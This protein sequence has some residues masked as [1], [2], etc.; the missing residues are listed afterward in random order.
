MTTRKQILQ[1][2]QEQ[3]KTV[4]E[5][6]SE[7]PCP[8]KT[9]TEMEMKIFSLQEKKDTE[10]M[11]KN[12][13]VKQRCKC[14]LIGSSQPIVAMLGDDVILPCHMEP[15]E[16]ASYL[17]LEWTRPDLDRRFVCVW[18]SGEELVAKKHEHFKGRTSLFQDEL[19]LG[20][21]SL[22][23]SK[24]KLADQGT[25]RCF[26]PVLGK[27]T[28]VQLVVD[29]LSS[30]VLT[31]AGI[32]RSSRG[33]ILS[34]ESEGWYPQPE[35]SWL[36]AEGNLLP[37]GPTETVRGPDGLYAVSSRVS[38]EKRH[39]NTFTCR[40][41]QKNINRMTETEIYILDDFFEVQSCSSAVTVGLADAKKCG[42]PMN[43][44][45]DDISSA[46]QSSTA[47]PVIEVDRG[48]KF[49][50]LRNMSSEEQQLGSWKLKIQ[51][52]RESFT[53]TFEESFKLSHQKSV[54]LWTGGH[55]HSRHPTHLVWKE[56]KSWSPGD[57]LHVVLSS[58][59]GETKSTQ[60]KLL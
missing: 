31:L 51:I 19:K 42:T 27:Q 43:S 44:Q 6:T 17:M 37:A 54:T 46:S 30:P 45:T 49:I 59:T 2:A 48:G 8:P 11:E 33:V 47:A 60:F 22:K 18:R 38:V 53:Y 26:I 13:P 3:K 20:N 32:D 41:Q 29:A 7:E 55:G 16:D 57:K 35:V 9:K 52:N 21:I 10:V 40:V 50:R 12:F 4:E 15:V 36:D 39:N 14:H 5:R 23:L 25:Y 58:N 28:F 24:V 56:L 1:I 34:C